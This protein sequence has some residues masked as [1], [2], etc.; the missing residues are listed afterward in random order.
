V[1]EPGLELAGENAHGRFRAA[2]EPHAGDLAGG[3]ATADRPGREAEA[4]GNLVDAQ[5]PVFVTLKH[6]ETG[7]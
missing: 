1:D 2:P 6:Y 3:D 7:L 5:E 4:A